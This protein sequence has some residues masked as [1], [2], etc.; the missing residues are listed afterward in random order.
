MKNK[1]LK[2]FAL[3]FCFAIFLTGCASL[4]SIKDE[5]GNKISF[6]EPVYFEGQVAQIGDYLF[7]GS[8]YSDVADEGFNYKSAAK[9]GSLSRLN[10]ENM[11]FDKGISDVN[12]KH[13]SPSN[14]EKVSSKLAGYA[15]Q[16]MFAY[17]QYLYFTSAN[18]AK[19]EDML[20]D[21]TQ[22]SLFR[23]KFNGEGLKKLGTFKYDEKSVI[24]LQKGSDDNYYF[25]IVCPN[26][27]DSTVYD[28]KSIKVGNKIGETQTLAQNATSAVVADEESTAR[29]VVYT[30]KKEGDRAAICV[31]AVDFATAKQ[32]PHDRGTY[33]VTISLIGRDDDTVFYSHNN[34]VKTE[35][36]YKDITNE[37]SFTN[38][39]SQLF[40]SPSDT[41]SNVIKVN[42]GYAFISNANLMFKKLSQADADILAD[43]SKFTDVL[44]ADGDYVYLSNDSSIMRV[45]VAGGDIEYLVEGMQII[46]GE[47]GYTGD[48]I[49]FYAQRG[50]LVL[51]EG[52]EQA[53]DLNY[54]MYRTD[55]EH[56]IQ[57]VG[58]LA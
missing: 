29:N 56:N 48:Y 8:A 47:C 30:H 26:E 13:S 45:S 54:Y 25:V 39:D 12:K 51:E 16:E 27:K 58:K 53:E 37:G 3:I 24:T 49:Y 2:V 33:D 44:F 28:I 6:A 42:D 50:K 5:E 10:V 46:S 41:I 7:Y 38:E 1:F 15:N 21:Y 34:G 18:T 40:Y 17:G 20:N 4:A 36:Y 31:S 14:I 57:L 23:I 55:K 19:S 35:I 11:K 43:S 9:K 32:T 52:E 22:V